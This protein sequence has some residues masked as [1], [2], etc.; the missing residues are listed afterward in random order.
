M[1]HHR[2]ATYFLLTIQLLASSMHAQQISSDREE[3][4]KIQ[5]W[6]QKLKEF[7]IGEKANKLELIKS[8]P[9]ER[10]ESNGEY[11]W[12]A[13]R[14]SKGQNGEII[15]ADKKA[16]RVM[17]YDKSGMLKRI[18]GR[19]GQGPGEFQN[20]FSLSGN[21]K[22]LVVGDTKN[23]M[24]NFFDS[25]G[26]FLRTIK[27]FKAYYDIA[28]NQ[29]GLIYAAPLRSTK[30]APLIDVLDENGR[31]INSFGQ[32]LQGNSENW[33]LPNFIIVDLNENGDLFIAY[34]HHPVVCRFSRSG[35]L[36]STIRIKHDVMREHEEYNLA[37]SKNSGIIQVIY[38]LR[39]TRNRF[40]VLH[41]YPRT[42]ILEYDL[43]G[44]LQNDYY[45]EGAYDSYYTD[46]IVMKEGEE[47]VFYLLQ[48]SPRNEI[49]IFRPKR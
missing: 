29:E 33:L 9:N 47:N 20:P 45:Y 46:F 28:I 18:I 26:V 4:K 36:E 8:F 1:R 16:C 39:S 30:E 14:M 11:F 38:A 24:L 41:N 34:Q 48:K 31:L 35:Q 3:R 25:S 44:E 37:R 49:S 15:V 43:Q 17:A 6:Q 42:E 19:R 22:Y 13:E 2:V 40:F 21:D 10:D 7:K 12:N 27:M 5:E 32:A 23:M